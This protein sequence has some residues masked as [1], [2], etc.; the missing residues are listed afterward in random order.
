ML[1]NMAE[2]TTEFYLIE[3]QHSDSGPYT[4]EYSNK[5]SPDAT[6]Q[7][8]DDLLLLVTG[9]QGL[10]HLRMTYGDPQTG[11]ERGTRG[12]EGVKKGVS[13]IEQL[14]RRWGDRLRNGYLDFIH[15][16]MRENL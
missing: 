3:I 8:S 13:S 2:M 10:P 4:C 1:L 15:T 14:M 7:P 16:C 11:H 5:S 9:E 12:R 6:S